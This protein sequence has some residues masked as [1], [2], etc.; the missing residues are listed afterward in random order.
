[1]IWVL[2]LTLIM[3]II[4]LFKSAFEEN[5]TQDEMMYEFGEDAATLPPP[6]SKD[7][8]ITEGSMLEGI[9]NSLVSGQIV[10][11][12]IARREFG[13]KRVPNFIFKLR[14][15]GLVIET[16][17]MPDGDVG[18]IYRKFDYSKYDKTA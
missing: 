13:C 17:T 1:M 3:G 9:Y 15:K 5:P 14:A 7:L 6:S 11:N 8:K 18:Y 12:E 4:G 2:C 10:T 16:L